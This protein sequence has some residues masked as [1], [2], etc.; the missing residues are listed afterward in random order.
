VSAPEVS[1]TNWQ[2]NEKIFKKLDPLI[3]Y[4]IYNL[5]VFLSFSL[6]QNNIAFG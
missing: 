4:I 5:F 6:W 1:E 2:S 3:I